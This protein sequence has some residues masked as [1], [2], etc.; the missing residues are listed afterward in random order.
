MIDAATGKMQ[1]IGNDPWMVPTRT[2][3]PVWSPD[4]KYIAYAS[5]LRSMYHAIFIA[6]V[7]TG[8]SKQVTDGLAD[9]V[10]PAWDASGKYLWFLASTDFGLKS[11][12]LDMTSYDHNE[13]FGLYVA[14]LKKGEPS[15]LLPES[16]EDKGVSLARPETD[17]PQRAAIASGIDFDGLGKRILAI[18]GV[19]NR[20]YSQLRA[21]APGTVFYMEAGRSAADPETPSAGSTL[22]R[23]RLSDRKEMMFIAGVNNFAVSADGRKLVYHSAGGGA[24]AGRARAAGPDNSGSL[25]LVDADGKT[26]PAPGTPRLNFALKM[27]LDPKEEFKQIFYEGWRNQR[28]YLYV[29]NMH[30]ANWSAMKEM[31]GQLLPAVNHRADLNYLIDMMGS[32]I[33]IGHSY[34]RGGDIPGMPATPGGLLGADFAIENGRYKITRIYDTEN[35]NPELKAPLSTPGVEVSVGDYILAVD[36]VELKGSGQHLSPARRNGESPD[37]ADHQQPSRDGRLPHNHRSS[38]RNRTRASFARVG[39]R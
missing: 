21:G 11:Q 10:W 15:P 1:N 14:V 36:G 4:S 9:A 26:A 38:S 30:G 23:Y 22:H 37:C 3:N 13:N 25:F 27:Y 24:G 8:E 12:W 19:A 39:G 6:N 28:D 34:V 16:D 17:R 32:E 33:S 31:Y 35:W 18:P 29:K 5:H 20:Q 7:E 2:L